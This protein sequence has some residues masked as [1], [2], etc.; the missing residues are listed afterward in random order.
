MIF[1]FSDHGS[2]APEV[3]A[4]VVI[5]ADSQKVSQHDQSDRKLSWDAKDERE[6][7]L[8]IVQKV[9]VKL[10]LSKL[11]SVS[12]STSCCLFIYTPENIDKTVD[13]ADVQ[14]LAVTGTMKN[15][16][17]NSQM[18]V[19]DSSSSPTALGTGG[20]DTVFEW[21]RDAAFSGWGF[22]WPMLRQKAGLRTKRFFILRND[23]LSYHAR[24]PRS[25]EEA[26][27]DYAMHSLR[28][29]PGSNVAIKRRFFQDCL[30]V[31]TPVDTLWFK[32]ANKANH[33]R[34]MS[35]IQAAIEHYSRGNF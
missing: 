22:K 28:L 4:A 14:T 27:A 15:S 21:V 32:S 29:R 2:L 16:V 3:R 7:D 25:K 18:I 10:D 6:I 31:A 12:C 17:F 5:R 1:S 19:I 30:E 20:V 8:P 35:L 24:E 9:N 26:H 23:L 13:S 11:F 33:S 34:W